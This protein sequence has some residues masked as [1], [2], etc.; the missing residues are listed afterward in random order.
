MDA[1]LWKAIEE[2]SIAEA[3]QALKSGAKADRLYPDG[4]TPLTKATQKGN[5]KIVE[6]LLANRVDLAARDG[7][8]GTVLMYALRCPKIVE[9]LLVHGVNIEQQNQHSGW[10]AL[11]TAAEQGYLESVVL[12]LEHGADV[13]KPIPYGDTPLMQATSHGYLKIVELLL[14]NGA[15][16]DKQDAT[17]WTA[18][19]HAVASGQLQI[20]RKLLED[21]ADPYM[22]NNDK[23]NAFDLILS[24]WDSRWGSF[25]KSDYKEQKEK[26]FEE[27]MLAVIE[28]KKK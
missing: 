16:I 24:L 4:S 25:A 7:Y 17:G 5:L 27:A 8:S 9:L 13:N 18:L 21:G 2:E 28:N 23:K 14:K 12:L 11:I 20:T 10:T 22:E 6:L 26:E 19:M 15:K 3:E 1:N